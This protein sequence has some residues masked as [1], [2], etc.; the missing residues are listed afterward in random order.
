MTF[1]FFGT[2]GHAYLYSRRPR[3]KLRLKAGGASYDCFLVEEMPEGLSLCFPV[4]PG[5]RFL[6]KN[7]SHKPSYIYMYVCLY[8][9]W[10]HHHHPSGIRCIRTSDERACA[11]AVLCSLPAGHVARPKEQRNFSRCRPMY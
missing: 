1:G 3:C 2:R 4:K 9:Y 8:M 6:M 7:N 11:P 5:R 10:H